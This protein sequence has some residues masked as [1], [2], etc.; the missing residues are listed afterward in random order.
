M[1]YLLIF[2]QKVEKNVYKTFKKVA[3]AFEA[4]SILSFA[5]ANA[6]LF[7]DLIQEYVSHFPHRV[8]DCI[9]DHEGVDLLEIV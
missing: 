3:K 6:L 8:S 5:E 7:T 2:R 4:D 9:G 1:K